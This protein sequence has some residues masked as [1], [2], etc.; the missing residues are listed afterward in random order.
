MEDCENAVRSF[1]REREGE[2]RRDGMFVCE[3]GLL[4]EFVR[5]VLMDLL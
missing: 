3:C 2:R 1:W 4:L 5:V